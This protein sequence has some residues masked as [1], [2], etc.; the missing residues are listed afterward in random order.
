M[1]RGPVQLKRIENPVHRQVTFCKRRAGL[2]KKAKELSVLCDAEIGVL[3]FSAHGKLYELATKGTMQGLVERYVN[4]TE[5]TH[6]AAADH[7]AKEKQVLESKEEVN[8]MK[9]EIEFLQKGL[10]YMY[11]GGIGTMALDELHTL[12]KHLEIW[13]Y[14][15]RSAKMD[16]MY[17]EIQLLKNKIEEHCGITNF[18]PVIKRFESVIKIVLQF[19]KENSLHQTFQTLQSECQVSL[20][21]VDS[22]ETFVADIN[23]G[24]W[25]TI[26]PQV[27]QLKLPR[28][29]LEDLYEQIVLEMIELRELDTARAIL[30][31]TQVMGV[32]KQEQPERYLRMEHLLVRTY[33]DPHEAYQD[34][35][36]EKRR[37]QIA[38]ALAAEVSVVPPSR[39]MAL[40][41]QALKWQQHQGLLPPGTQFDLFRGTAAMKQDVDDMYA[42][43]LGHTIKFGKK[44]HPECAQFSPDGQFLVSCSVDGFVEVWDHISGKLKKDLQYQADETFMM[45]DDAALCVDFS[46]DSEMLASGSQDGKIKVWRIRTG[47]CLRRLEHAHSQGV[48]SLTFSRDGSQLLSTSF[49]GTARIHGLKSGKLLKEFRGHGSYVNDAIFTSDGSRVITAS[50]DFTVKGADASVN[51]VHLFPKNTDHIIVCNKTSS[52]HLMTLQ[53]QV[54]KSFSSGKKEGGDFVA[55]CVSPKGEWI[56]CVG[57]DRNMYCFSHQSGKLE[58]LMK[59][60]PYSFEAKNCYISIIGQGEGSD[61]FAP[62][63]AVGSRREMVPAFFIF[64]D[65]LIDNGN[66]NNLQSFAKANY[67]P[68]GIDFEGG[69]TG[70]FSNGYTMVD[71]IAEL[72]GLPLIPAYSEASGDQVLH[73]V[74]YASAAAGI[75]DITGRN[76]VGRIPFNQQIKNFEN[77]LDQ[78]TGNLGAVELAQALGRSIFF[79]GMGSNDYLNN[80]LMPNYPTR[81]EYNG[82]HLSTNLPGS[83]FTYIDVRN[84]F[85]DI[86]TNYRSYGFSVINR[87]CCGIGRNRGQITC[88][89]FQTPCPNRDQYVFWDAFHPTE[90]VNIIMG[91]KAFS[92]D[93]TVVSP[94]N[95]QQLANL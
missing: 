49:D 47:Q 86:L 25:D 24:R 42:T 23:S 10:S 73:G 40:I 60:S 26:L 45:H 94:I 19:C 69:P 89:P 82:Q 54:V 56:Y 37:S 88:L 57:E 68:Y 35:T 46:R 11:G 61:A 48:T 2:L 77:T 15:I 70:R 75:L 74:N 1:A 91:R 76:F 12:E 13:I 58:H 39:L 85:N 80:Y 27:A 52:I 50:S 31:Q 33:F 59:V 7:V 55:A 38:Q 3:I 66:N 28:K 22:L 65:S 29:K 81:N 67:Y 51:S 21:T 36:K 32:M 8:I 78:I 90:A 34:S 53:G 20:N 16:I 63:E 84:M 4:S 64:G 93:Q 83:H 17:Q 95:I 6:Q 41:G 79:V 62:E 87:G 30:R 14:H 5:E 18:A 43:N 71:E 92:G 72:L 44:S 9:H